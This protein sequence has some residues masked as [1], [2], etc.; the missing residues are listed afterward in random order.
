[1]KLLGGGV[2]MSP[3]R[4]AAVILIFVGAAF[5]VLAVDAHSSIEEIGETNDE[6]LLNRVTRLQN[7]RDAFVAC[8]VG[9]AFIGLFG[10]FTLDEHSVPKRL[11]E[12]QMIS[13]ARTV[14][15]VVRGLSLSG[16]ASYLPA[17]HGL[18]KERV[19]VQ[20]ADGNSEPP[21][22][23]SDDMAVAPGKSGSPPGILV[24][25]PGLGLMD[26]IEE[27]YGTTLEVVGI[28]NAEGSLQVLKHGL[29]VMKDF[30]FKERD[31]AVLLRVEYGDL[32]PACRKV[33]N[34][35][36]D[37]CRQIAC[38]GCSCLL[39]AAARATGKV[40]RVE[41]V[42]NASDIVVFTLRLRNW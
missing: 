30:H 34:E 40:V 38:I 3:W 33:R 12:N 24:E 16:N 8:A 29:N 36:P 10:F 2:R 31:D 1:M 23:L 11:A 41:K 22:A 20:A 39:L 17:S 6:T 32:M 42:D 15:S 7:E 9:L 37:T 13:G 5:G 14:Q 18:T 25:P 19:F 26:T 35:I 28:E 27:D 21:S 4:F